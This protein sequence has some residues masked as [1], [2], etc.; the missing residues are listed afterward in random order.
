MWQQYYHF[1]KKWYVVITI[2]ITK[3]LGAPIKR[4][5]VLVCYDFRFGI[6]NEEEDLTFVIELALFSKRTIV[7]PIFVRLEQLVNLIASIGLN[8][9]EHV[10]VLPF[11]CDIPVKP[12]FVLP[13]QIV[14]P[15]N[16]FK[17]HLLDTFFQL[18][19]GKMEIDKM[20]A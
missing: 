6:F 16:T 13:I 9:V 10:Y 5:K 18:E 4:P 1:T 2:C 17:Q 14:I 11:P 12:I 15:L 8:L 7:V 20:H 19:V 3:K